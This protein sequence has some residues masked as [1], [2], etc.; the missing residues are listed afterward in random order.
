MNVPTGECHS[1][2]DGCMHGTRW[3][4]PHVSPRTHVPLAWHQPHWAPPARKHAT[5]LVCAAQPESAPLGSVPLESVSNRALE[6][7]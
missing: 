7:G 6:P 3:Q 4:G 5:E 1:P 2:H